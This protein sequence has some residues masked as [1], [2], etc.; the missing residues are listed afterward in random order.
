MAICRKFSTS[1][2]QPKPGL[3][4]R[5]EYRRHQHAIPVRRSVATKEQSNEGTLYARGRED[6]EEQRNGVV[7]CIEHMSAAL[8]GRSAALRLYACGLEENNAS[9][10]AV[11]WMLTIARCPA[12]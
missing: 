5:Q 2:Q 11:S 9:L 12:G 6:A 3:L 1:Q 7:P 8:C 10:T 4:L